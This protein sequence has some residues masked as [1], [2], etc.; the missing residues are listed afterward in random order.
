MNGCLFNPMVSDLALGLPPVDLGLAVV[1]KGRVVLGRCARSAS[2]SRG[3]REQQTGEPS[4]LYAHAFPSSSERLLSFL[5]VRLTGL[6]PRA[7]PSLP[8][9]EPAS[10]EI[11]EAK[12]G[13]VVD[14]L[15]AATQDSHGTT[16]KPGFPTQKSAT[17]ATSPSTMIPAKPAEHS[18]CSGADDPAILAD[19]V[20]S[21]GRDLPAVRAGLAAIAGKSGGGFC[22]PGPATAA[23]R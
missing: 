14:W 9:Y 12:C 3:R 15:R 2:P 23:K 22:R 16:P 20:R 7:R 21:V 1:G 5:S 19:I 18:A 6:A 17:S 4:T 10:H 13:P 8:R 11:Q